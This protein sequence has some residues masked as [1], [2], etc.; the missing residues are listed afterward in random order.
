MPTPQKNMDW[1]ETSNALVGTRN[2]GKADM[3][4]A[5]VKSKRNCESHC[6]AFVEIQKVF[7]IGFC[8]KDQA[9]FKEYLREFLSSKIAFSRTIRGLLFQGKTR[10]KTQKI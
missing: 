8:V 10:R 7:Q 5:S 9:G 3:P 6:Y 4:M 2:L 1:A